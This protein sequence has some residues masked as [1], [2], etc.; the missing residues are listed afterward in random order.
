M[1]NPELDRLLSKKNLAF[2]WNEV[3]RAWS[4]SPAPGSSGNLAARQDQSAVN[5]EEAQ[6]AAIQ[7]LLSAQ[8]TQTGLTVDSKELDSLLSQY[9]LTFNWGNPGMK[10]WLVGQNKGSNALSRT[11]PRGA[12]D[13]E[14]AKADAVQYILNMHRTSPH[15]GSGE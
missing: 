11:V 7:V 10:W 13:L 5:L 14:T 12:K 2:H 9:R 3:S 1:A 4:L 6:A 15:Q 8:D